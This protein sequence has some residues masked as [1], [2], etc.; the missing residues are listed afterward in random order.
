MSVSGKSELCI[1]DKPLPQGVIE[2]AIFSDVYPSTSID[3]KDCNTVEFVIN[4]S[5]NEYIDLNDTLLYV[6]LS[7]RTHSGGK[8]TDP[9]TITPSNFFLNSLFN[10]VTLSLN[11]TVVEGG[12]RLYPYKATIES[13]FNFSEETRQL[14]LEAAGYSENEK[15]RAGWIEKSNVYEMAG[16]L[17]LDFL[18]QPKY[19]IPGVNVRL[20]LECSKG[21]FSLHDSAGGAAAKALVDIKSAILYVRRVKV[22]PSVLIGHTVG[23][24]SN[25]AVYPFTRSKT[26]SYSLSKDSLS[27]SKENIFGN[28]RLPKFVVVGFVSSAAFNGSYAKN[29]FTFNHFNVNSVGLYRDGQSLPFRQIY[30]PDFK[31]NLVTRDFLISIV[32]NTELLNKNM[33]NGI[34]LKDFKNGG[35]SLFTFNLTPD[36][37]MRQ[38]QIAQDGNLRLDVMFA[39]ALPEAINIIIYGIFDSELQ[40]TRTGE[41]IL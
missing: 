25:N 10:N 31:N 1:F 5:Q 6:K 14:Q 36:F 29:P 8:L 40:I 24:K 38:T 22:N 32:Q 7:V 39:E 19:L 16:S 15:D 3:G 13:I 12:D 11:N 4:G 35:Y 30:Q 34:A 18:N 23:M 21:D 28:S 9:C 37:S 41:V 26:V 2:S 17:R 27:Y 33:N 20:H